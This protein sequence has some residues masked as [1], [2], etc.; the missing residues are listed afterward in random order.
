MQKRS[1]AEILTGL[2]VLAIAEQEFYR[3][4]VMAEVLDLHLRR[5]GESTAVYVIRGSEDE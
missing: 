2:V 4:G 5:P 1:L 3:P